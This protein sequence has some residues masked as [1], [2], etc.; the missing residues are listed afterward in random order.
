MASVKEF[1]S[2]LIGTKESEVEV[3]K[4][5]APVHVDHPKTEVEPPK[6]AKKLKKKS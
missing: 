1:W 4:A 6:K 3:I 5:P 2:W